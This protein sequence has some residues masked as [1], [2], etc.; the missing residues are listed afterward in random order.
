MKDGIFIK[1]VLN[2]GPAN[3]SGKVKA[4]MR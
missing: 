2:R 3:E 4:G 1:D